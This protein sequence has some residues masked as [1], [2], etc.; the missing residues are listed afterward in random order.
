MPSDFLDAFELGLRFKVAAVVLVVVT[1][2]FFYMRKPF[3]SGAAVKILVSIMS[4]NCLGPEPILS[5]FAVR[6]P[7]SCVRI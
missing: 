2:F 6:S 5:D 7:L 3:L 4:A 1:D